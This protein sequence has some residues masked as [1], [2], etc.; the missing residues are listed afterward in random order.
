[1]IVFP[2]SLV[3][4]VITDNLSSALL[5]LLARYA[6]SQ[7]V[8]LTPLSEYELLSDI[9]PDT[10]SIFILPDGENYKRLD[11]VQLIW[12]FLLDHHITRDG[13]VINMGGGVTTDMGGF[14]AATYMR[15]VDFINI[16]TTLLA[17]VD[18]SVGDKTGIDYR[19][20]KNTIGVFAKPIE[21]IIYPPFLATLPAEEW[22]SGFAEMLKHALLSSEPDWQALLAYDLDGRSLSDLSPL[23][24]RSLAVKQHFTNI[25]PME[26][27]MRRALNFGH[28]IGHAIETMALRSADRRTETDTAPT[29]PSR[30]GFCVLWGMVAEL[31]LSVAHLG[32]P[33]E[34]LRQL[35]HLM[36]EYYGRPQCDCNTTDQLIQCMYH[37]KKNFVSTSHSRQPAV[38]INFTLLR[39]IGEPV[40]NCEVPVEDIRESLDYLFSL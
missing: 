29:M 18:A 22:L 34:P 37:D 2:Y 3:E 4:P 36:L 27:G 19:G 9:L 8:L 14:A 1:M 15:G 35:S 10:T 13:L 16:P 28:T 24:A 39:R 23:L 30:H 5:P 20:L 32:F 31:Y 40:I 26:R 38:C 25:D 33:R 12:D 17:M 21:T 11:T 6:P 7:T